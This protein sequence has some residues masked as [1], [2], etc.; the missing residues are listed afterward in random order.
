VPILDDDDDAIAR[1][2]LAVLRLARR[3]RQHSELGVTASQLSMLSTIDRRGPLRLGVLAEYEQISNATVTRLINRLETHGC[4]SRAG[5]PRDGRGI[6][7]AIT[8]EGR[9]LLEVS[10]ARGN[11]YL[12][13]KVAA[14]PAQ[15]RAALA[16]A[17]PLLERLLAVQE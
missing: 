16:A 2:R 10:R 4:V 1:L 5:D 11:A 15:D 14:L 12:A 8:P 6:N 13:G 9:R 17:A 3:L 7:V